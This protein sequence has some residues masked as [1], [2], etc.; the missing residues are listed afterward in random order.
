MAVIEYFALG[1]GLLADIYKL[2]YIYLFLPKENL[3]LP[4]N[5]LVQIY[6]NKK[7]I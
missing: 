6:M 7:N 3:I 5:N 2:L 1:N 4:L